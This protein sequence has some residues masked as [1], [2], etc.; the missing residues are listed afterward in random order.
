MMLHNLLCWS[1]W[2][3]GGALAV[4]FFCCCTANDCSVAI[5]ACS[6]AMRA[7]CVE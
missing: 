2:Q 1:K 4:P 7:G 3:H 5:F 6:D